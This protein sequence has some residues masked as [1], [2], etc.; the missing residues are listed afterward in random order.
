MNPP[1]RPRCTSR[2]EPHRQ[3]VSEQ[4]LLDAQ[5]E[6]FEA[7]ETAIMGAPDPEE[8]PSSIPDLSAA[9]ATYSPEELREL[10]EAFDLQVRYDKRTESAE[11]S[12]APVPELLEGLADAPTTSAASETTRPATRAGQRSRSI[13]GVG[14]EPAT[15]LSTPPSRIRTDRIP[16]AATASLIS[17][18]RQRPVI[19]SSSFSRPRGR[20]RRA[21]GCPAAAARS[22]L[23]SR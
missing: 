19:S 18:R 8:I 1:G 15:L 4:S 11:I 14:S 6:E 17:S 5:I 21:P 2:Q 13:A 3:L 20:A 9:L 22:R 16:S 12:V 10:F 7:E 23:W